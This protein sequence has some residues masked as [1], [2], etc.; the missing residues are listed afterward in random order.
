MIN[1]LVFKEK[2]LF[3]TEK[4]GLCDVQGKKSNV[5]RK[6]IGI[7][8]LKMSTNFMVNGQIF[9]VFRASRKVEKNLYILSM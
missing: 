5:Y 8:L 7:L 6:F 3:F 1:S 4:F 2:S 9:I